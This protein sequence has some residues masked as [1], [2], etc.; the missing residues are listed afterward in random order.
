MEEMKSDGRFCNLFCNIQHLEITLRLPFT[1][2]IPPQ[3]Q[4]SLK[5]ENLRSL[6]I[7][8]WVNCKYSLIFFP[9]TK[10]MFRYVV[11]VPLNGIGFASFFAKVPWSSFDQLS[12][13]NLCVETSGPQFWESSWRRDIHWCDPPTAPHFLSEAS[14][15]VRLRELN[16]AYR[17]K[18][19]FSDEGWLEQGLRDLYGECLNPTFGES[20]GFR[21]LEF[22]STSIILT[23]TPEL[24]ARGID[25]VGLLAQVEDHLSSVFGRGGRV[26][27]DGW[28]TDV[29]GELYVKPDPNYVDFSDCTSAF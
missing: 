10:L 18:D 29:E 5:W 17:F 25:K 19:V 23:I 27:M 21:A 9:Q 12:T 16:V 28:K 11:T 4:G 13:L 3:W 22:F 6:F 24:S 26:E 2:S 15:L 20:S 1:H 7:S 14:R 8:S